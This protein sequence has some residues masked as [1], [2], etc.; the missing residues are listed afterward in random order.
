MKLKKN[1]FN[2]VKDECTK[3]VNENLKKVEDDED[4]E[5]LK[6]IK[7]SIENKQFNTETFVTDIINLLDVKEILK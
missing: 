2:D 1:Y 4:S 5:K 3:L 7:E 6:I